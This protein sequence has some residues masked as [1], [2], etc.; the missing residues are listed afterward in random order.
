MG[1]A[2]SMFDALMSQPLAYSIKRLSLLNQPGSESMTERLKDHHLTPVGQVFVKF[3][4]FHRRAKISPVLITGFPAIW[5]REHFLLP[6]FA[7]ASTAKPLANFIRNIGMTVG[8]L[9]AVLDILKSM[10]AQVSPRHSLSRRPVDS[11]SR[12]SS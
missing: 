8:G 1:V 2:F 5:P 9:F 7:S 12:A 3:Q 6:G 11:D 10:S 4:V